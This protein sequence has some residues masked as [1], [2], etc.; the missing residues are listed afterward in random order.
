MAQ[1]ASQ[2]RGQVGDI[3]D[4]GSLRQILADRS[5][6]DP[7]SCPD[8]ASLCH[9]VPGIYDPAHLL[10]LISKGTTLAKLVPDLVEDFYLDELGE[11]V[12]PVFYLRPRMNSERAGGVAPMIPTVGSCSRLGPGGCTLA[13][14]EMP[15]GCISAYACRAAPSYG[16]SRAVEM[17]NTNEGRELIRLFEEESRRQTPGSVLGT[18]AVAH[19]TDT[20]AQMGPLGD[21]IM[22]MAMREVQ[23]HRESAR[24]AIARVQASARGS[25]SQAAARPGVVFEAGKGS[26]KQ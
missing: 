23:Q 1:Q 2:E 26:T 10:R 5:K 24:N 6:F 11:G 4:L 20:L 8:C 9:G 22:R 18:E 19:K 17:W 14:G 21:I 7:C 13:R 3:E 12:P 15:I 25:G 16:K